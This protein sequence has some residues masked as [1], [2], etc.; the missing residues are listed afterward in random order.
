MQD[1]DWTASSRHLPRNAIAGLAAV[2]NVEQLGLLETTD[3]WLAHQ[4]LDHLSSWLHWNPIADHLAQLAEFIRDSTEIPIKHRK[5]AA[6]ILCRPYPMIPRM[7]QMYLTHK[8]R[9]L[10]ERMHFR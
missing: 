1:G 6:A 2:L 4:L 10:D 3:T 9:E 8:F 5:W 7:E